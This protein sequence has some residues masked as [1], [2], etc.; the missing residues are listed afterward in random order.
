MNSQVGINQGQTL[1]PAEKISRVHKAATLQKQTRIGETIIQLLLLFCGVVSIFTT[2]SIVLVL[3]NDALGFFGSRAWVLARAPVAEA[4][5]T[6]VLGEPIDANERQLRIS[7]FED[8]DTYTNQQFIQIGSETMQV[9]GRGSSTITVNRAQDGTTAVEHSIEEPIFGM[10]NEQVRTL[11]VVSAED[12]V[13]EIGEDFGR[14][15]TVGDVIQIDTEIMEVLEVTSNSLTVE[16]GIDGTEAREHDEDEQ[17][18]MA[19]PVT[20]TAFLT[21]TQWQPQVGNFGIWP[22]LLSTLL[23]TTISL[24]VAVPLGLGA[25]VYLSEYAPQNVKSVMKPVLELLAGIPTVV[26]G[27]FALTFITPGLQSIFSDVQFYNMLSAGMVVGIL[28]IPYVASQSEDA[29]SAVPRALREASYGLGATRLETTVKIVLPAAVSGV[30]ASVILAASRAVGET[31]IVAIAAG[32][33]PN[34]TFN[35]FEG[36]ETMTGH[37]ARISGGDLSYN[38]IDYNSIFAIGMTLFIMTFTLNLFADFVRRRLQEQ[39]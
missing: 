22:L 11:G 6:A 17:I 29:L 2:V 35:I 32:A 34:F 14:E 31:M 4:E 37:I 16:R 8:G 13:I 9:V 26:F 19:V 5:A 27:F 30:I 12:T 3:G 21:T 15:F 39:Y 25:A 36:A 1:A 7:F 10:S 24:L 20:L 28:L 38:S 33:G 23:I 18:R